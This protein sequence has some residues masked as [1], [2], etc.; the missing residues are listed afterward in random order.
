MKE[1]SLCLYPMSFGAAGF[2]LRGEVN[3]LQS[4]CFLCNRISKETG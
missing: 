4:P 2:I 1:K 3:C